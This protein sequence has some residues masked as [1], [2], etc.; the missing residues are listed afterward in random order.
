MLQTEAEGGQLL[1][2][3][4]RAWLGGAGCGTRPAWRSSLLLYA[5]AKIR[6]APVLH[7]GRAQSA[8]RA[9]ARCASCR[10]LCCEPVKMLHWAVA[11]P[12]HD[13]SRGDDKGCSRALTCNQHCTSLQAHAVGVHPWA[14]APV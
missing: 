10:V 9:H 12:A 1:L 4:L 6:S 3:V 5:H 13:K 2:L 7:A 8:G 11:Q 14:R